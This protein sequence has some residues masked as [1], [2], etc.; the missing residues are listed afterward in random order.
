MKVKIV[1]ENH[2]I[3]K[4]PVGLIK[5][6]G[7]TQLERILR[8]AKLSEPT[9]IEINSKNDRKIIDKIIKRVNLRDDIK[10]IISEKRSNKRYDL[11]L[12]TKNVYEIDL[13]NKKIDNI[14]TIDK[15]KDKKIAETKIYDLNSRLEPASNFTTHYVIRPVGNFLTKRFVRFYP[16]ITP[17]R[18]TFFA[19]IICTIGA[20]FLASK[21]YMFRMLGLSLF[22]ISFFLDC[23]DGP[24]ARITLNFSDF[25]RFLDENTDRYRI[26]IFYLSP[27]IALYFMDGSFY[28]I[29]F[30]FI[31]IGLVF[32]NSFMILKFKTAFLKQFDS[33]I[34]A[35]NIFMLFSIFI[36][37]D[38]IIFGY[39]LFIIVLSAISVYIYSKRKE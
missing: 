30:S 12:D 24:I 21:G 34:S 7:V 11:V 6:W 31:L 9:L 15:S 4:K 2:I 22:Y 26:I 27:A 1:D 33:Y 23:V 17:N 3:N 13:K 39:L 32:F 16:I 38:Q 8:I 20:Y 10:V 29:A 18:I 35:Q 25:G 19:F 28:N 14:H 5:L 37:I 36:L